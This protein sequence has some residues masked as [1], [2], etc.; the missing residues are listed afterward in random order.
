M[1]TNITIKS[2]SFFNKGIQNWCRAAGKGFSVETF[3]PVFKKT[4]NIGLKYAPKLESDVVQLSL[5][6]KTVLSYEQKQAIDIAK[7][8]EKQVERV[9]V[10]KNMLQE[11]TPHRRLSNKPCA[12]K[13]PKEY[14][15][16]ISKFE[17]DIGEEF[18]PK[19]WDKLT[20]AQKYDFIV[21]DRYSRLVSNKIMKSI[22]NESIEHAFYLDKNGEIVGHAEGEI[23]SVFDI[24]MLFKIRPNIHIHNHPN[25]GINDKCIYDYILTKHPKYKLKSPFS[26]DDI[27]IYL[28]NGQ[29]GYLIDSTGNIYCYRPK[30]QYCMDYSAALK[31]QNFINTKWNELYNN[32]DKT[33][34]KAKYAE[35]VE[36][37]SNP[38]SDIAVETYEQKLENL[39]EI[40]F[41]QRKQNN[42]EAWLLNLLVSPEIKQYGKFIT[43]K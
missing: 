22:Q 18:L 8:G 36:M 28:K 5:K 16:Y 34:Y 4:E 21:K 19:D 7:Y 43:I 41:Q 17:K 31:C 11:F 12:L 9:N 14:E 20:D 2:A 27:A 39:K 32:I 23:G 29:T 33:L 38:K 40:A 25:C 37:M 15:Y 10:T 35:F 13:N 24:S 30:S 26:G 6:P 1:C 3:R 42:Q